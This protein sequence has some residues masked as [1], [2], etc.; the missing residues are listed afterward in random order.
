MSTDNDKG[1]RE[2]SSISFPYLDL[3]DAISLARTMH[4]AGGVPMDRDQL[5]AALG[6]VPTSGSFNMKLSTAR[7]FGLIESTQG[8]YQLSTLGFDI[9]DPARERQAKVDAFLTVPL[10]RKAFDEFKGKQLPARPHGL[11]RAFESFGVSSKQT[12]KARQAF[13]RSARIAGFFSSSAED[14]LVQPVLAPSSVDQRPSIADAPVAPAAQ[15][16]AGNSN[17]LDGVITALIDKLPGPNQG[18][19]AKDRTKWLTMMEMAFD[20]AYGPAEP[21][22][23]GD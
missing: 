13:D 20:M 10:Y 11:E 12:D 9:L 8:R 7:V 4:S 5:A 3:D 18:F 23:S 22:K 15:F 16:S 2:V 1:R 6:Q 17:A 19:P 21:P 14:R